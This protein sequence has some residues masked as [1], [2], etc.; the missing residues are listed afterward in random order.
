M[1]FSTLSPHLD[2]GIWPKVP[3]VD[4][5]N[6]L[7]LEISSGLHDAQQKGLMEGLNHLE[8]ERAE[9]FQE[10]RNIREH[11]LEQLKEEAAQDE[12]RREQFQKLWT[13]KPSPGLTKTFHAR[14]EEAEKV[15]V[16]AETTH[17]EVLALRETLDPE[18]R[19]LEVQERHL[20]QK[21]RECEERHPLRAELVRLVDSLSESTRASEVSPPACVDGLG[22]PELVS[23]IHPNI[24][25]C[26]C[27][28]PG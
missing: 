19:V 22:R 20:E 18:I 5:S 23:E 9:L 4:R 1:A 26:V 6:R 2:A 3:N 11:C 8:S 27:V 12:S 10:M 24:C 14:I 17:A 28:F 21:L 13:M 16:R 15:L 7:P 25:V